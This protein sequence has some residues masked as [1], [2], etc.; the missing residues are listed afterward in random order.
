M[1]F[2]DSQVYLVFHTF[3][4]DLFIILFYMENVKKKTLTIATE[5]HVVML[6]FKMLP[7]KT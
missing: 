7:S 3:V 1:K 6:Y 2:N 4:R 5:K